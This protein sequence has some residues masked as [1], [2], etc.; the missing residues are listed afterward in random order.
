MIDFFTKGIPNQSFDILQKDDGRRRRRRKSLEQKA[1]SMLD[2]R[3]LL[4]L[5][6]LK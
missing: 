3:M 5:R 4:H 2:A 6:I 1:C